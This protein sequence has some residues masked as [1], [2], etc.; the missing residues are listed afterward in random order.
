MNKFTID[1]AKNWCI[2]LVLTFLCAGNVMA[3]SGGTITGTISDQVTKGFLPGA[4]VILEGTKYNA[5]T[6]ND[7]QYRLSGVEPGTY[8]LHVTYIGYDEYT[9]EVTMGDS[10]TT[11]NKSFEMSPSFA[12]MEEV[13]VK[14]AR[15]GQ[16][17]SLNDQKEAVNI[18]NVISE[19][20]IQSFPDLNTAEV[21]QRVPGVTIQRSN[22]EGRFV[23]MRGT[24]P[25]LTNI[26]V[27]GEPVAFS[28]GENRTVEL[29]VIS[30]SQLTGIEVTKVITPDMDANSIG[31]TV[32]LKTRSAFDQNERLLNMT[33]GGG[34]NEIAD[35]S[36]FRGAVNFADIFGANDNIGFSIGVNYARTSR[37]RHNNEHKW[38]DR[39]DEDGNVIPMALRNIEVQYSKNVR[40]RLGL[41]SQLEFRYSE[42]SRIYLRGMY[43]FRW[44]DQDRQI[45]RVRVDK[46][47]YISAT[48]IEGAR[49]V[50]SLNDREETQKITSF[51]IGGEHWFGATLLDFVFSSSS[52]FTKKEDGQL[53][54]EF[55]MKKADLL[56]SGLDTKTPDWLVTNGRDEHDGD[57]YEFDGLDHKIENTT[58]TINTLA[59]N[60]TMPMLLGSD[61]GDLKF[62]A[63]YRVLDKDRQDIRTK[64]KW[65]G[66]DLLLSQ[67]ETGNLINLDNGYTLGRRFNRNM[68]RSFFDNNQ[69]PNGFVP[70]SRDDVNLG[71]P[72]DAQE[73][74]T[75]VYLMTTQTYG[76][77]L[78]VAGVRSESTDLD[79]IASNLVL[80]DDEVI[81]NDLQRVKSSYNFIFPN[82]QFRWRVTPRTNIR[83]AYS[84]GISPPN[85]FDAMP[86]SFT[87][88]DDEEIVRGNPFLDPTESDN[89]D[90]LGEHF[91][92][93]I[94]L[95]S[96]GIFYKKLNNFNFLS[97][98]KEADG[99]YAGFD[100]EQHVNGDG[101]DLF[102]VE[103]SW[104]QQFTFLPGFW[105]G[106]G[107]YANYTY[108]DAS[109]ID[110]G[111]DT[112]REH[113]A[114]LPE[115]LQ[116]VGN[117]ALT[118]ERGPWVSRIAVNYSGKWIEEVGEDE[119][120]DEWR[121]STTTVD[122]S[123]SYRFQNGLDIFLQANNLTNEVR[124]TYLGIPTRSRKHSINGSSFDLGLR[125]SWQ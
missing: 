21:L 83:L 65:K 62:G 108:T 44:D 25:Q 77:L 61:S 75:S 111:P 122:F 101:A 90:L 39:K 67:F 7:G 103:L 20:L 120:T 72:Y 89:F 56:L 76:N 58:S 57:N 96:G 48:E 30:A 114:S 32:N 22:G 19:E 2:G 37:E 116:H 87:Q 51:N 9:A 121:D 104:Q 49:F 10:G 88:I 105:S 26:L 28:N 23:S 93:G 94:G 107:V 24:S 95:L 33:L 12:I 118:Y 85:F 98:F 99:P 4:A 115:Q 29:D 3:Q 97:S 53:K 36:N 110:L 86:Y 27:N 16:S 81:S 14:G 100:V 52:A 34:K 63:K 18:K 73:D 45:T 6:G 91:F 71:E 70:Q 50:K 78:V 79:Y 59:A 64:F 69:G 92:E 125:W 40:D 8:T 80:D 74:T 54:P 11:V 17:K 47:D 106:F 15:F 35:G 55:Q 68:F 60:Y 46:G 42:N 84:R 5:Q 82:L 66:D 102:G 1:V 112:D 113:I 43:N 31:G 119:Q 13:T 109:N 117:F 124:Y 38:G 41:N 123:A